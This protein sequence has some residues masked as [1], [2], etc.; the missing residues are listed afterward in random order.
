LRESQYSYETGEDG[1]SGLEI[2]QVEKIISLNGCEE[3]QIEI[4]ESDRRVDFNENPQN[5]KGALKFNV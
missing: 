4:A 5:L 1:L 2:S 3:S